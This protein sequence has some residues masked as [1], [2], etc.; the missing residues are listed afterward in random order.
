MRKEYCVVKMDNIAYTDRLIVLPELA[1]ISTVS[2]QVSKLADSTVATECLNS[3][4]CP[5]KNGYEVNF[6]R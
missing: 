6:L 4:F 2:L 1:K 5:I 3:R